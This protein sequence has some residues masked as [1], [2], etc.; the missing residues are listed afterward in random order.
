MLIPENENRDIVNKDERYSEI[1]IITNIDN[2]KSYVG[3]A[4]SHILNNG[5]YRRYG[6]IK[7]F[8]CHVSEAFSTK[9]NQCH[10]LN[11]AIRKYGKEKFKVTLIEKCIIE[12]ADEIETKNIIKYNTM[13]PNGYNLKYGTVTTYLSEEGRKRVSNG[14]VE[15]YESHKYKRFENIF[16]DL[17]EDITEYIHPLNR[18]GSQYGWYV[19][20]KRKKADFGGIHISLDTSYEKAEEFL[21]NI[22]LKSMAKHLDAGTSL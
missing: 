22:Q 10:Y 20:V 18:N 8:N 21:Y 14:L 2:N 6:M 11:S 12:N 4:V 7:R 13:F 16:I 15:Y 9:E 17:D 1:Y 19:L 3:Q 5:K